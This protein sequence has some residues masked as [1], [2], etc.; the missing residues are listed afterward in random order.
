MWLKTSYYHSTFPYNKLLEC[1]IDSLIYLSYLN[2]ILM[3]SYSCVSD[4]RWR[5]EL[6]Y[7]NYCCNYWNWCHLVY[8]LM[9]GAAVTL[10]TQTCGPVMP[11][12]GFLHVVVRHLGCDVTRYQRHFVQRGSGGFYRK[13]WCAATPAPICTA[14]FRRILQETMITPGNNIF[15]HNFTRPMHITLLTCC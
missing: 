9:S 13:R 14:C 1:E 6:N 10:W 15:N 3:L 7:H 2:L 11:L 12:C 8:G 5:G 4:V